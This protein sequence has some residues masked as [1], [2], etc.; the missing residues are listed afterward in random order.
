MYMHPQAIIIDASSDEEVFHGRGAQQHA[1][2]TGNTLIE[3]P[4]NA[5]KTLDWMTKLDSVALRGK[6]LSLAVD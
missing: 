4:R 5:G 6:Q 2:V 1:R 3:L